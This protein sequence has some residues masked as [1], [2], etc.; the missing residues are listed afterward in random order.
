MWWSDFR[1]EFYDVA[2]MMY[3][4]DEFQKKSQFVDL[5]LSPLL[6][7]NYIDF[8]QMVQINKNTQKSRQIQRHKMT[9]QYPQA[10]F[11]GRPTVN[12]S[13]LPPRH[14]GPPSWGNS[15]STQ[16]NGTSSNLLVRAPAHGMTNGNLT[17]R[18]VTKHLPQTTGAS[19]SSSQATAGIIFQHQSS[20]VMA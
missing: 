1:W 13:L 6:I 17:N 20:K 8:T 9:E 10:V 7:P 11:Q 15:I 16:T 14:P 4:E 18:V 5:S 3:I 19:C 2:T 12:R